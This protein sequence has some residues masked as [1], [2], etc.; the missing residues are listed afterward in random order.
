MRATHTVTTA[1]DD[2]RTE[3]SNDGGVEH[4]H[5]DAA[6]TASAAAPAVRFGVGWHTPGLRLLTRRSQD[7]SLVQ[8]DGA[9]VLAPP[10]SPAAIP[11]RHAPLL[12]WVGAQSI[13]HN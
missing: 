11:Y 8:K 6:P 9:H 7:M 10:H 12:K 3:H 4:L 13:T 1:V 5:P 2:G